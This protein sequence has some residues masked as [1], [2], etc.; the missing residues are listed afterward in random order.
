ME[1]CQQ[2]D[3]H[4]YLKDKRSLP[5]DEARQLSFQILEG[6]DQMH[7]MDFAHRDLKPAVSGI[8]ILAYG[9][10]IGID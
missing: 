5:F 1:Y 6:L 2:G 7:G 8:L 10:S 3:L 4:H 9:D